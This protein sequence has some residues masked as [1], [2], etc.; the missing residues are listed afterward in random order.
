MTG[1]ARR[2]EDRAVPRRLSDPQA[3]E[4]VSGQG[5]HLSRPRSRVSV[6]GRALHAAHGRL[7]L[8]RPQRRARVR[9]RRLLVLHDQPGRVVGLADVSWLL[10]DGDQVLEDGR[11]RDVP[12]PRAL[13]VRQSAAALH[14]RAAARRL[15]ARPVRRARAGDGRPTARSSTTS[16]SKARE[17]SCTCATRPRRRRPRR[18][19][20]ASTSPT[21]PSSG[22]TSRNLRS[23]VWPRDDDTDFVEVDWLAAHRGDPRV[24]VVDA[25]SI[26]HGGVVAMPSG[27]EQY[28]AGH[29][30]GAVHLDYADDLSDP[31]TPYAARVAPPRARSR[32]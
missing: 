4:V 28:A 21:T 25:R 3:R 11:R 32:A 9:A 17:A 24:R 1:G 15:S 16:C 7:D 13:G 6:L 23:A 8:A 10:Q 12:R 2:S 5:Q 26:P 31:A 20:S 18:W 14:P 30:P 27:R 29:I 22:S 19:R